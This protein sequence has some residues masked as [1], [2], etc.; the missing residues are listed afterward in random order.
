MTRATLPVRRRRIEDPGEC[1][2][3]LIFNSEITYRL[4]LWQQL[5]VVM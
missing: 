1:W 2:S 3:E 5:S 4:L